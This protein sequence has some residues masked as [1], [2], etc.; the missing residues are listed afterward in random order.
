MPLVQTLKQRWKILLLASFVLGSGA[1]F[2]VWWKLFRV[3]PQHTEKLEKLD[4]N[5]KAVDEALGLDDDD[6][7]ALEQQKQSPGQ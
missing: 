5:Q 6:F 4:A 3:D 7:E 2:G 1:A